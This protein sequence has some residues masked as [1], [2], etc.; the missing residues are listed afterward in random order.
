MVRLEATSG[1]AASLDPK[2][3]CELLSSAAKCSSI[4]VL[5]CLVGLDAD[6]HALTVERETLLRMAT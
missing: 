3:Q 4:V 1:G 5:V 6:I 2:F